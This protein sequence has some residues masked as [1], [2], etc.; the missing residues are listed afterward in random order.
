MPD[1][2]VSTSEREILVKP[3]SVRTDK[4]EGSKGSCAKT[5]VEKSVTGTEISRREINVKV[6]ILVFS[7]VLLPE[8]SPFFLLNLKSELYIID[9]FHPLFD[10]PDEYMSSDKRDTSIDEM[11]QKKWSNLIDVSF[12]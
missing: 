5:D 6:T 3:N 12:M 1:G 7:L 11:F 4:K 8:F 9:I 10:Y 2:N